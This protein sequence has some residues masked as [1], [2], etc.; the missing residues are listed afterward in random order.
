MV[1]RGI[2]VAVPE[3]GDLTVNDDDGGVVTLLSRRLGIPE[4]T[5]DVPID[6]SRESYDANIK[7]THFYLFQKQTIVA[8]KDQLF[9]RQNERFRPQTIKDTLPI[10]LGMSSRDRFNLESQL[11]TAQRDLRL[12]TKLLDEAKS[13]IDTS[14]ERAI[15]LHS[16]AQAVGILQTSPA[17]GFK[18]VDQLRE[19]LN[20]KPTPVPEDDGRRITGIENEL[21]TL[22]EQ[23]REIQRRLDAAEQYSKRADG[24]RPRRLSSMTD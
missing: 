13:A 20:W 9:Y 3:F 14:E 23:R 11:R 5:S 6:S 7:H 19:A 21:V 18:I 16:E 12:N 22:R 1:R 2:E 17:T 15:G 10:L 24:F 8:N 4:N